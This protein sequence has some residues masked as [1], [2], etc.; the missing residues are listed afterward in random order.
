M[1]FLHPKSSLWAT[2]GFQ[3]NPL[4]KAITRKHNSPCE[5]RIGKTDFQNGEFSKIEFQDRLVLV[6]TQAKTSKGRHKQRF[7]P[8]NLMVLCLN[9]R[10]KRVHNSYLP[11]TFQC[12]QNSQPKYQVIIAVS[13]SLRPFE[14]LGASPIS[15]NL[16]ILCSW[17]SFEF[18]GAFAKDAFSKLKASRNGWL[19]IHQAAHH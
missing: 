19:A 9:Q 1:V 15:R 2:F 14:S 13:S 6:K 8:Q 18:L 3:N 5:R 7:V 16:G 10:E 17:R 11:L 12:N 4:E